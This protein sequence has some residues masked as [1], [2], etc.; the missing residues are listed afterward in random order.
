MSSSRQSHLVYNNLIWNKLQLD[1]N[2]PK[3][4]EIIIIYNRKSSVKER[5]SSLLYMFEACE[6]YL[7]ESGYSVDDSEVCRDGARR[8]AEDS[9]KNTEEV[10]PMEPLLLRDLEPHHW[11]VEEVSKAATERTTDRESRAGGWEEHRDDEWNGVRDSDD[12]ST[13]PSG[14]FTWAVVLEDH[15]RV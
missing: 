4:L 1:P 14:E 6:T 15:R 12:D 9:E 3:E 8:N 13:A 7:S 5:K 2:Q 10:L 11:R